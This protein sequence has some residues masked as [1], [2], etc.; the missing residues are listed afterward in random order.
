MSL[1]IR[2]AR[3]SDLD[4][5]LALLYEADAVHADLHPTFFRRPPTAAMSVDGALRQEL[6]RALGAPREAI[7]VAERE[8]VVVGLAH[9]SIY[10][11]PPAPSYV[12]RRRAHLDGLA[13][14]LEARRG[15]VGRQ[16]VTAVASWARTH[17]ATQMLLT[18]WRGNSAAEAFYAALGYQPVSSV[19]AKDL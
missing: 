17:G 5:L 6:R 8:G 13:V 14:A 7:L 10:D 9:A 19:M 3:A 1:L 12:P 18:V 15:G 4:R 2:P 16:L 11:T